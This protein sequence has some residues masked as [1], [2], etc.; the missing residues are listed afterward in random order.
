VFSARFFGSPRK[1]LPCMCRGT[2]TPASERAVGGRSAK[3]TG[4]SITDPGRAGASRDH[5]SG[6]RTIRGIRR[7]R[8]LANRLLHGSTPPLSEK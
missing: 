3:P 4:V 2:R 6:I 5:F 8:S 1:G 7:P